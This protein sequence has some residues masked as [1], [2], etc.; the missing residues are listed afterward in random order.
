MVSSAC[1]PHEQAEPSHYYQRSDSCADLPIPTH[2]QACVLEPGIVEV[3][4]TAELLPSGAHDGCCL[5]R[6]TP[7]HVART[8]RSDRPLGGVLP[9]VGRALCRRAHP[10][11]VAQRSSGTRRRRSPGCVSAIGCVDREREPGVDRG[12]CRPRDVDRT[13]DVDEPNAG[14]GDRDVRPPEHSPHDSD[15]GRRPGQRDQRI[16]QATGR[17]DEHDGGSGRRADRYREAPTESGAKLLGHR[18]SLTQQ[19]PAL[20]GACVSPL[21]SSWETAWRT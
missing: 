10:H 2:R 4:L 6:R 21:G 8:R 17:R 5:S 20:S 3:S 13:R 14:I 16:E 12:D 18:I 9:G 7:S 1:L 11:R 19:C 15:E